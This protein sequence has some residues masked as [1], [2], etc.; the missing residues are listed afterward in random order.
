MKFLQNL[1]K[2]FS[3]NDILA[4]KAHKNAATQEFLYKSRKSYRM[5]APMGFKS[6]AQSSYHL[7]SRSH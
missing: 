3:S 4:E 1:K 7:V 6:R 2:Q 5:N